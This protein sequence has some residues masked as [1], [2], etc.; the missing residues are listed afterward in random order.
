MAI[1][2]TDSKVIWQPI[3]AGDPK[4]GFGTMAASTV[5]KDIA[6]EGRQALGDNHTSPS[7]LGK[8]HRI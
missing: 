3:Q 7:V 1:N 8:P 4:L 6:I 2:A 5:W